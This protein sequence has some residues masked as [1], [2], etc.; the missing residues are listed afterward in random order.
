MK[1][2]G[3]RLEHVQKI[4]DKF[5]LLS[6]WETGFL[7]SISK[8]FNRRGTLS[9]NQCKIL[10]RMEQTCSAEALE[11]RKTWEDAYGPEKHNKMCENKF[12]K[13]VTASAQAKEKY[14]VGS[15][16][17]IRK[18]A[19]DYRNRQFDNV[20]CVVIEVLHGDIISH[21]KGAKPYRILPFGAPTTIQVEERH[22]KAYK[23]AKSK[24]K[25]VKESS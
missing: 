7:E 18:T 13:K 6:Q 3:K 22:I 5:D 14:A 12:A 24:A 25:K 17:L 2:I 1:D 11:T 4:N 8:Q 9:P 10:A 19:L 23:P 16:V 21:A 15:I 20:L